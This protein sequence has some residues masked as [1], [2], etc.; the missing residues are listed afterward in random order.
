MQTCNALH[1][2]YISIGVYSENFD[3]L[4]LP[5]IPN[6]DWVCAYISTQDFY[7][8]VQIILISYI[9]TTVMSN[10]TQRL[11]QTLIILEFT[12]PLDNLTHEIYLQ[13]TGNIRLWHKCIVQF[14]HL[15]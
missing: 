15:L 1:D 3:L 8:A 13:G 4:V 14:V 6:N 5:K 11:I 7:I 12:D 10:F 9:A 2:I